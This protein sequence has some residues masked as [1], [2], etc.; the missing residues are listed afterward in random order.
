MSSCK[1]IKLPGFI[2]FKFRASG[3]G[4]DSNGER[5]LLVEMSNWRLLP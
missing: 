4:G 3:F 2:N 1:I 5:S